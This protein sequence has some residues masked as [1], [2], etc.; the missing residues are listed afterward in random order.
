MRAIAILLTVLLT[1][2]LP[3][4]N[5]GSEK[6]TIESITVS[7]GMEARVKIILDSAPKGLCRI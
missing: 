3:V 5:A 6:I 1:S 7:E 4:I 2:L